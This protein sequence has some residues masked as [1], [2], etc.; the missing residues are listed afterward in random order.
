MRSTSFTLHVTCGLFIFAAVACET[1]N[2]KDDP[3]NSSGGGGSGA[4]T[5]SVVD[6]MCGVEATVDST[7]TYAE[8]VAPIIMKNCANC[9][10]DGGIAPFTLLTYEETKLLAGLIKDRTTAREMPPFNPNNCGHCNTF[11][12]ARWLTPEEIAILA[13]WADAGAPS[14]DLAKAPSPPAPPQGLT[15]ANAT[16]D[17]GVAYTPDAKL[18]DDYRCFLVD[19]QTATDKFLTGFEVL[20]GDARVVHH[21]IA[22]TLDSDAAQTQAEALDAQDPTPGYRCF[23]GAEV[24]SRFTV[25][26]A[27]GGGPT[28]F[29]AGTGL[30]VPGG[31]KIVMQV[32]YNLASGALPD[33]TK[34]K[35]NLVD[36]VDKEATISQV[37]T[38]NIFLPPGQPLVEVSHEETIPSQVPTVTIWGVAPHMHGAG[39]TMRVTT[40]SG[41]Q[42]QCLIDVTNWD[43]HWQSFSMYETP[44]KASGG[45]LVKLTCGYDTT[46]RDAVTT[47]GEGTEDEMCI[48]FFYV[49][50]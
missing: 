39:K 32:H 13:A 9:H 16:W 15:E 34:I 28:R 3:V 8:V 5:A 24:A 31:R 29:P 42:S 46:G 26:W 49:T 48:A 44:L 10:R 12:D 20:P 33:Q 19:A 47:F 35:V 4:G 30:R 37:G 43:F 41:G 25:G 40:Q 17:M 50:L 36:K 14:G 1:G 7:P 38:S 6:P 21:V 2:V 18:A 23:G 45:D 11:Q 22:Y 27:P